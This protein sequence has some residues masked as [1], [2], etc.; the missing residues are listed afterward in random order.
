MLIHIVKYKLYI[1]FLICNLKKLFIL[2]GYNYCNGKSPPSNL[3]KK[4]SSFLYKKVLIAKIKQMFINL[5]MAVYAFKNGLGKY[6]PAIKK[7][8]IVN[9][10]RK[11]F[12]NMKDL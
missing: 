6:P 5:N 1:F 10:K 2:P 7:F 11:H 12:N 3:E 8:K 4:Y 9:C